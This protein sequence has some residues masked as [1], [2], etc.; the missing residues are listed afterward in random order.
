V[1]TC[2]V[3]GCVVKGQHLEPPPET[4]LDTCKGCLPR[5]AFEPWVVCRWHGRRFADTLDEL[6]VFLAHLHEIGKPFAQQQPPADTIGRDDPAWRSQLPAPWLAADEIEHDAEWINRAV[7]DDA[8]PVLHRRVSWPNSRPWRGDTIAWLIDHADTALALP[9]TIDYVAALV[10]DVET[11]RH[12]WPTVDD[13][14]PAMALDLPC[15]RCGLRSLVRRPVIWPQ[16][17]ER[18]DCTDPDCA[19]IYTATEYE[20]FA[21]IALDSGKMGKWLTEEEA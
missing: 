4:H 6:R 12:R 2:Q 21:Q 7:L 9:S 15:P 11:A 19:R 16:Q 20:R 8:W 17:T 14:R 10:G 5:E 1:S 13:T 18:I 3:H